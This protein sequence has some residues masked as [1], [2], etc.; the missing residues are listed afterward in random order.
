MNKLNKRKERHPQQNY[1]SLKKKLK[2]SI[3]GKISH[4]C[5]SAELIL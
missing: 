2:T 4:A 5:G 1:K 3:D